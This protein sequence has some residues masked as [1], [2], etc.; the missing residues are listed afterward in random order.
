[1]S[2]KKCWGTLC[3]NTGVL[4]VFSGTLP[5]NIKSSQ[6]TIVLVLG[7]FL[8]PLAVGWPLIIGPFEFHQITHFLIMIQD[9]AV[10][11]APPE[12]FILATYLFL[13][14]PCFHLFI[15]WLFTLC[16]RRSSSVHI[17]THFVFRHS[18]RSVCS[19][20][21]VMNS[22]ALSFFPCFMTSSIRLLI[23]SLCAF[24]TASR[25]AIHPALWIWLTVSFG[26]LG[27]T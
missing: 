1:M 7:S 12:V 16:Y 13:I 11:S 22:K 10:W 3:Q 26:N 5:C 19:A 24:V 14:W 17:S 27:G 20:S 2:E 6:K 15:C 23:L 21:T 8:S 18:V 9:Y 4:L 25:C